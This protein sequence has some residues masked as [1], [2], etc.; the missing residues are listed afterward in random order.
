LIDFVKDDNIGWAVV[1]AE[2]VEQDVAW[3]GLTVNVVGAVDTFQQAV[4]GLEAGVVVPAVDVLMVELDD[5]FAE[6]FHD[7]L[8]DTG[9]SDARGVI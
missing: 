9:F 5:R 3:R 7:E 6:A 1:V 8:C 2:A 4:E